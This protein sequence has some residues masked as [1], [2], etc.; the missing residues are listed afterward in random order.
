MHSRTMISSSYA[1]ADEEYEA[2]L[3]IVSSWF[4]YISIIGVENTDPRKD[5]KV[6]IK[7]KAFYYKNPT[8]RS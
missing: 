8:I 1:K 6:V 4:L 5:R 2:K 7:S 3:K